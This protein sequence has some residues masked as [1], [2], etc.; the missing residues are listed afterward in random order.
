MLPLGIALS[1]IG[2]L[3]FLAPSL[4]SRCVPVLERAVDGRARWLP[5]GICWTV[6][7]AASY[8]LSVPFIGE[9]AQ[10]FAS[11][12]L[13][14]LAWTVLADRLTRAG[15]IKRLPSGG[16][17]LHLHGTALELTGARAD[18]ADV[19]LEST[20]GPLRVAWPGLQVA[21]LGR[22]AAAALAKVVQTG[23]AERLVKDVAWGPPG[24]PLTP[25][26]PGAQVAMREQVRLSSN[27]PETEQGATEQAGEDDVEATS[28]KDS[29]AHA[30]SS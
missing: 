3:S 9:A 2:V 16:S 20:V 14:G 10:G 17:V 26:H 6:A 27:A 21:G 12:G 7:A 1:S 23:A 5:L 25:E 19:M 22:R 30:Q 13:V 18:G 4:T 15:T 29:G 11:A 8:G 28:T 24:Y